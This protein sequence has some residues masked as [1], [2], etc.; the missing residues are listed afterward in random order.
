MYLTD[1]LSIIEQKNCEIEKS[2]VSKNGIL[3]TLIPSNINPL[4]ITFSIPL[5]EISRFWYPTAPIN[6][7]LP[8]LWSELLKTKSNY[9]TPIFSLFNESGKNK[10]TIALS[11]T[12][13]EINSLIGV[14]EESASI[15]FTFQ[16]FEGLSNGTLKIHF[17]FSD[18]L[19][20][21]SIIQARKWQYECGNYQI[22]PKNSFAYNPVYST[23][24]SFHQKIN[25]YEV[26]QQQKHFDKY[27]LK[28]IILDDGWQTD[29]SS[30]RYA[31]AG[32]WE[33]SK[34][35]FPNMKKHI[36]NIR[37]RQTR[38]L[39]WVTLPYV[40]EKTQAFLKFK[41]KL[42]YFDEFQKAGILDPRY[43]EVREYLTSRLITLVK[44]LDLDGLKIDFVDTFKATNTDANSGMDIKNL[45]DA[46]DALLRRITSNC[47]DYKHDFLIEFRED[48]FGTVMNQYANIMRVKDCPCDYNQNRIGITNLRLLCPTAAPHSDMV[49]FNSKDE[50]S[51]IALQILNCLHGVIQLSID[52]N[53]LTAEQEKLLT[54]WLNYQYKNRHFIYD[55]SF[56]ALNPQLGYNILASGSDIKRII[57]S[58]QGNQCVVIN[59]S[60]FAQTID[61]INVTL[62]P[63]LLIKNATR[64]LMISKVKIFDVFG[65]LIDN[66]EINLQIGE[67]VSLDI[68]SGGFIR[69]K[70]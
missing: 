69:I 27:H 41:N 60:F 19:F 37:Q 16:V 22:L 4:L 8:N 6:C 64:T 62:T 10:V 44:E 20:S 39:L 40:G 34:N 28:A 21:D 11:E 51:N 55:H 2:I 42:L 53:G 35:K 66:S 61:V 56:T 12:K 45:D 36:A 52:L 26:E 24:Y 30:R 7:P 13:R 29:D 9:S 67:V 3:F 38:Y 65:E 47:R 46:I 54:Y 58:H 43:S 70:N 49:M 32:D 25:Q 1:K 15:Y 57:T 68:P 48:Y 17:D 18:Q 31:F 14:H 59:D 63:Q 33:I 50:L 5:I 23:W